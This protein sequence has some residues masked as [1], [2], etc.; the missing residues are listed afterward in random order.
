MRENRFNEMEYSVPAERGVECFLALRDLMLRE[1]ISARWPVE[2][3][4]QAADDIPT[5]AAS[6]RA[7]VAISIHEAAELSHE[8]FFAAAEPIFR[9]HAGRPHWA[10]LHTLTSRDL[11]ALYPHW[12]DF[13]TVRTS[14]DP[15][16]RFLSPYLRRLFVDE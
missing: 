13:Q 6:G 2:Y 11:R 4:T 1:H 16:G 14:V 9:R 12:D 7:T 10:K 3:R 5:S 15:Q 8:A